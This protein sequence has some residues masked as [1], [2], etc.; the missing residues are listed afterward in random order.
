MRHETV[1]LVA[2]C[3]NQRTQLIPGATCEISTSSKRPQ[4]LLF[5]GLHTLSYGKQWS[6]NG[7]FRADSRNYSHAQW[8]LVYIL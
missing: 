3:V 7:K 4:N 2:K 1:Q 8:E 5:T 6:A